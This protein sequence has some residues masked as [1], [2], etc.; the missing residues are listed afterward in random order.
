VNNKGFSLIELL[1]VVAI[2]G[3][4]ASVGIVSYNSYVWSTKK[5]SVKN[6]MQQMSLAQTEYISN[7]SDY[8]E[9]TGAG[10]CDLAATEAQSAE[11]NTRLLESTTLDP[12]KLKFNLCVV[13][14][15]ADS[16]YISDYTIIAHAG[17]GKTC[18]LQMHSNGSWEE[19]VG[20]DC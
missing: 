18:M 17:A 9:S 16:P 6:I 3:I 20:D 7:T 15:S 1:T 14:T 5:T 11:I 8:F 13:D 2:I 12:D 19:D 10:G 4:L